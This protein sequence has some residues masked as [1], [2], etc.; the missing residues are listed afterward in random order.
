MKN[1][2]L[3]RFASIRKALIFAFI[4]LILSLHCNPVSAQ[5]L[6]Q[7]SLALVA[8]YN[9][10]GGPNWNN[11]SN[12]L[13]GPVSTWYG[14]TVEGDRVIELGSSGNFSFNNLTGYLPIEI[15]NLTELQKLVP[16]NNPT[17]SGEIPI[18]IG[19]L[20]KLML[21]G[22]GNCSIHGT[23]P[24]SIG[25]CSLLRNLSL[26]ENN[27][28]GPI[29]TE[30]GN[31]DSLIFLDLHDNQLTGPIPPELG[32]CTNLWEI[33]LYNNQLTGTVPL[34]VSLLDNLI[35]L[36]LSHNLFSGK[37]PEYL[38][39]L[40]Y[41]NSPNYI[42]LDVSNNMFSGPVPESWGSQSFIIDGLNLSYNNFTSLPQINLNWCMTFFHIEGNKLT[43][44]HIESHYQTY[45]RGLYFFFYYYPQDDMLEEIDTTFV[46]GNNFSIYSG[47]GG[48]FTN[49]KW[50]K[51]N[52][53][54]L[55]STDADTLRLMDVSYADT[56]VY[57][58][59]AD[60][61]LIYFLT[62]DRRPVHITIDTTGVSTQNLQPRQ[63]QVHIFPNP[64]SEQVHLKFAHQSKINKVKIFDMQ[65]KIV[66]TKNVSPTSANAT[67]RISGLP[68]GVYIL[69]AISN[70]K[71]Y[72]TKLIKNKRGTNR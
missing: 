29:P 32:N 37:L 62:I 56:G 61:S 18:E 60:N 14:V 36:D 48:E 70:E 30:I 6:E 13:T 24:N 10:T 54:I 15:G 68:P 55:E 44:E 58:C 19:N 71:H 43:F 72:T 64:A 1:F 26:R 46:P 39:N 67:L 8:F 11:N 21:L 49:Y 28:T 38:N 45:L 51:D 50:F 12:W 23:I 53:L 42:T 41:Q 34:E 33:R 35:L 65:G 27:L 7:D 9:S 47:T 2:Y 25:N 59:Q 66:F 69:S 3:N 20:Q 5:V 63:N 31:L 22:I 40:F 4:G 16:G 52:Q 57:T 17:L